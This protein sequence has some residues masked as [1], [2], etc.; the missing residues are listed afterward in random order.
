MGSR[1]SVIPFFLKQQ[2]QRV[3]TITDKAMTR[4]MISLD[5]A[6]KLVLLAFA[7]SLGG[8]IYISKIPSMKVL[9]I[10]KSINPKNKI[11][12]IGVRPGEKLHEMMISNEDAHLT[13]EYK[14]YYKVLSTLADA[15]FIK[16]AIKKGKKVSKDFEYS[17]NT[18]TKWME[19]KEL[20][21]WIQA[22]TKSSDFYKF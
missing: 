18:N 20:R 10:A 13:Y 12:I 3:F 17:S 9:D 6:V 15:R 21:K 5:E 22:Y 19:I 7:D 8:E 11:K 16:K 1:G 14:N 2:S 4:F